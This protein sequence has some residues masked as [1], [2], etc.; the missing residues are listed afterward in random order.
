MATPTALMGLGMPPALANELGNGVQAVTAAG[1]AQGTATAIK[2]EP[3]IV[4]VTAASSQTGAILPS[5]APIGK[6]YYVNSVG[7]TAAVIY[8]PSGQTLNGTSNGGATFSAAVGTLI[9]I[10]ISVTAWVCTG[11]ATATVA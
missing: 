6:P 9:F 8:A 3:S 5:D 4:N 1:T 7:G 10:R 2:R 11:T